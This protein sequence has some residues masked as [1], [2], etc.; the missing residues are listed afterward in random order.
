MVRIPP[1]KKARVLVA[2]DVMLDRYWY[3]A[4]SRIS[5]EAPVPVVHV[6]DV[7]ERPGGA[8]NVA[9]NIAA[10]GARP[11]LIGVTGDDEAAATLDRLLGTQG[12][13]VRLTRL[14]GF[15]TV[16]KL[17]VVSRHQQL[18][19]LDFEKRIQSV[20]HSGVLSSYERALDDVAAV[21]LSDYGKGA[22]GRMQPFIERA[23][24]LRIPV[25]VDPKGTDFSHYRGATVITP[26]VAEFEAVVGACRDLDHLTAKG[27]ALRRELGL[28]ALLVTRGEHGMTLLS[29]GRRHFMCR[30]TRAMSMTS[31]RRRHRDRR[32]RCRRGRRP[33]ARSG[34]P[35]G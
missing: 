8:A 6:E 29:A 9:T 15:P 11:V 35:S 18:I 3:G 21:V 1:F 23:R 32:A 17:R 5:P 14:P 34:H 7:E 33:S 28:E 22:L 30:P 12:V 26:N 13:E 31:R 19:R 10:L 25:F 2:G 24:A 20:T 16:T 27:E 4:T